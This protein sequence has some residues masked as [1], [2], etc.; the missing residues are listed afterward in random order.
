MPRRLRPVGLDFVGSAPLRLVFTDE[1]SAAPGEVFKALAHDT[2]G[3]THWFRA[4]TLARPTPHGREIGLMG[5]VRFSETVLA[6]DDAT[7]YAYRVDTTNAPSVRALAEEWLLSPTASGGSCVQWTFA[8]D[9]PAAARALLRLARPG[10]NRSF[11]DAVRALDAALVTA[12][13]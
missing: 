6:A 4:V 13:G 3:W 2:E 9:A 7:R 8:V 10:L 5:G 11:R 1:I 12:R